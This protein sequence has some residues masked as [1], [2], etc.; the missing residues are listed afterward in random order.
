MRLLLQP[1]KLRQRSH[2]TR[3]IICSH[4]V[5]IRNTNG[6]DVH[7]LILLVSRELVQAARC[8]TR[9]HRRPGHYREFECSCNWQLE[10]HDRP[11]NWRSP[12]GVRIRRAPLKSPAPHRSLHNDSSV[13]LAVR[14]WRQTNACKPRSKP[15][16]PHVDLSRKRRPFSRIKPNAR[17][18]QRAAA[19]E[20][21]QRRRGEPRAKE[22]HCSQ[23]KGRRRTYVWSACEWSSYS[24]YTIV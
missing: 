12:W 19:G 9:Q 4:G 2:L 22:D 5:A 16:L 23:P 24:T 15:E 20:N 18:F 7:N 21:L 6:A 13:P 17:P 11:R 8:I 1:L 3:S 14:C 10:W